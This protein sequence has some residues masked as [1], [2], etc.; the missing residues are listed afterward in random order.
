[1]FKRAL[2]HLTALVVIVMATGFPALY[3]AVLV[4]ETGALG[5]CREGGC[6]YT[7]LFLVWPIFWILA[8]VICMAIWVTLYRKYIRQHLN[9]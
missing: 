9:A 2:I 1:M 4:A 8:V 7:A 3:G 5:E 6:G